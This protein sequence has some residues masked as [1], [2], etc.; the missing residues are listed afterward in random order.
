MFAL[1]P[2][3]LNGWFCPYAAV[4]AA[5]VAEDQRTRDALA[6]MVVIDEVVPLGLDYRFRKVWWDSETGKIRT[7]IIPDSE[8][9][10]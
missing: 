5:Y 3:R 9:L 10:R 8:V 1:I 7:R 4:A 6:R 2:H